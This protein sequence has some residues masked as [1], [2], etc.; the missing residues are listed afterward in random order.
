SSTVFH[1][2]G[3]ARMTSTKATYG[4]VNPDLKVKG[5][6]GLCVVDASVLPFIPSGHTQVA[7]YGF[8]ERASDLI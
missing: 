2:T 7:V 5:V 1:P 8:A 4:V 6:D 3:S